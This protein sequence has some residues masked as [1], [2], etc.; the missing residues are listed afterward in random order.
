MVTTVVEMNVG[1]TYDWNFHCCD[2]NCAF[3]DPTGKKSHSSL[4][5]M[6]VN[7]SQK[8][9]M[10]YALVGQSYVAMTWNMV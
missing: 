1:I 10:V 7:T 4:V 9:A 2:A 5:E 8:Y 6:N 3:V